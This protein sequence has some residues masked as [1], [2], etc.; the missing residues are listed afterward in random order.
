[1]SDREATEAPEAAPEVQEASPVETPAA[2]S[3]PSVPD[4]ST[5]VAPTRRARRRPDV[6]P[7]ARAE[8]EPRVEE[9]PAKPPVRRVHPTQMMTCSQ[10][11]DCVEYREQGTATTALTLTLVTS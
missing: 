4:N 9:Q 5:D 10:D 2:G 6:K 1:M 3:S 8:E 11:S 7:A